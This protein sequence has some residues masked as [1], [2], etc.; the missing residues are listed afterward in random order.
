MERI[1]L[2]GLGA[3]GSIYG[4]L[5]D[6]AY[7]GAFRVI[8]DQDRRLCFKEHP[9]IV[10]GETC[11]FQFAEEE[12]PWV[13]ADAILVCVK[14]VALAEA[15][16]AMRPFVGNSTV[17]LPLLNGVTAH[18]T[19]RTGFPNS[20]VLYGISYTI[21]ERQ[22]HNIWCKSPGRILFGE[23]RGQPAS[24]IVERLR[25]LLN[26]AGV[27]SE[28]PV[29]IVHAT[30]LKFMLNVA[31]NQVAAIVCAS[32]GSLAASP[33][34][35]KLLAEIASEVVT[36]ANVRGINLALSDIDR[37]YHILSELPPDGKSSMLQDIEA[38]RETEVEAFSGTVISLGQRYGIP[39][40]ANQLFYDL[41]HAIE[42]MPRR[43]AR[44][45]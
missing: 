42:E 5:L 37:L 39:T 32:Y 35:R 26:K 22:G 9:L 16:I 40:P 43:S 34:A 30:W 18:E 20:K 13:Y 6:K 36:I 14:T 23:D 11:S 1:F 3:L 2:I 25:D 27:A 15:M 7:P 8:M 41:Y 4:T 45:Y 10:D 21:A 38:G 17:I 33:H 31:V 12:S 44:E 19:L 24:A 28:I 29:D